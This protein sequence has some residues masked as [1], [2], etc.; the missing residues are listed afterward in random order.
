MSEV[1]LISAS[2]HGN[3]HENTQVEKEWGK[4]ILPW[5]WQ[6][7]FTWAR[8]T[9]DK[10][11]QQV[12]SPGGRLCNPSG[13]RVSRSPC[14]SLGVCASVSPLLPFSR[15]VEACL[16]PNT[17]ATPSRVYWRREGRS[18]RLCW[19]GSVV[20]LFS[21]PTVIPSS[22]PAPHPNP[23]LHQPPWLGLRAGMSLGCCMFCFLFY[24]ANASQHSPLC[25]MSPCQVH[26]VARQQEGSPC[27]IHPLLPINLLAARVSLGKRLLLALWETARRAAAREG[28]GTRG[29]LAE[30]WGSSGCFQVQMRECLES[31]GSTWVRL[32]V[33]SWRPIREPL[34]A[35]ERL[36]VGTPPG[37]WWV[38]GSNTHT[39]PLQLSCRGMPSAFSLLHLPGV[40]PHWD[41]LPPL[42]VPSSWVSRQPP[43]SLPGGWQSPREG[44]RPCTGWAATPIVGL[45]RGR[46]GPSAQ[47]APRICSA[48]PS[49]PMSFQPHA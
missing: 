44:E 45:Q 7:D 30:L 27:V 48:C 43:T 38:G 13:L 39:P 12:Q 20:T 15:L 14:K 40:G 49:A 26:A 41:L 23:L 11:K 46:W 16:R 25:L 18:V 22:P 3:G 36:C 28:K 42:T 47:T 33:S 8:C 29:K 31:P 19:A 1:C 21:F 10:H 35:P 34:R 6:S 37:F 24:F 32:T 4:G 9:L 5:R 17:N 2:G